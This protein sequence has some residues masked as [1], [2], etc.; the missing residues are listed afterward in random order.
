MQKQRLLPGKRITT[1]VLL[2]SSGRSLYSMS[3]L[4]NEFFHCVVDH[5]GLAECVVMQHRNAGR[6]QLF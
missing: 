5:F 4:L 6:F 3:Y 1:I 2:F